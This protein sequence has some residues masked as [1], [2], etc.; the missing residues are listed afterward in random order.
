MK[1]TEKRAYKSHSVYIVGGKTSPSYAMTIPKQF[2]LE[3]GLDEPGSFV[4]TYLVTE[5]ENGDSS[6]EGK[7][8]R[9]KKK[10]FLRVEKMPLT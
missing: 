7:H 8:S 2:A 5:R 1:Y 6:E 10:V 9:R 4:I 3:M